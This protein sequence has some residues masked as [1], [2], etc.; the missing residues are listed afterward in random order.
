MA[1]VA[2][3]ADNVVVDAV[4]NN[5]VNVRI[6]IEFWEGCDMGYFPAQVICCGVRVKILGFARRADI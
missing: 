2:R 6:A 5:R 4:V 1:V 3:V